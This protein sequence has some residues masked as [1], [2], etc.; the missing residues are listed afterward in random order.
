MEGTP[1]PSCGSKRTTRIVG[2]SDRLGSLWCHMCGTISASEVSEVVAAD[3]DED[4]RYL[5]EAAA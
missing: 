2:V 3:S 1:C 4:R 5:H